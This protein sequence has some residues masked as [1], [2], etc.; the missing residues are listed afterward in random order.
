MVCKF[1]ED[2]ELFVRCSDFNKKTYSWARAMLPARV[3]LNKEE[4]K[5]FGETTM[6][7]KTGMKQKKIGVRNKV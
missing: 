5:E 3:Q 1:T 6:K 2:H 4:K 7:K